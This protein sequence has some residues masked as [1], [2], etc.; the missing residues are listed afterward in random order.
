MYVYCIVRFVHFNQFVWQAFTNGIWSV[1][2]FFIVSDKF[3][4]GFD[5]GLYFIQPKKCAWKLQNGKTYLRRRWGGGGGAKSPLHLPLD[6]LLKR[7]KTRKTKLALY[8]HYVYLVLE[9]ISIFHAYHFSFHSVPV[10]QYCNFN[11]GSR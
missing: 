6:C 9:K 7:N 5:K 2:F 8:S 11:C 4:R 1:I 10:I 3:Q